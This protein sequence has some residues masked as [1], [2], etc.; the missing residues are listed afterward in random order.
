MATRLGRFVRWVVVPWIAL[1]ILGY[2]VFRTHNRT[3]IDLVRRFNR[4]VLN[5]AML[6]MAGS[7]HFYAARLEHVGRRTGRPYAT[8]VVAVPYRDGFAVPL[9]YG[10]QVD[11]L[12]NLLAT[13]DGVLQVHGARY[14]VTDPVVRPAA[15][16]VRDLPRLWRFL[17][18][19]YDFRSWVTV[20]SAGRRP[21]P[22]ASG[23][24]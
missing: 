13:G 24:R 6:T 17:T 7:S 15:D 2:V 8:P 14:P 1:R 12:R 10:E 19:A 21:P 16:V 22:Q 18:R 9:P 11:W 3:G 4:S 20:T 23:T 5:P